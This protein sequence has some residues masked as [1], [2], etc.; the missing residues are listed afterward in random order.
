MTFQYVGPYVSLN[1]PREGWES[2]TTDI[3]GSIFDAD[4]DGTLE[5][6][7]GMRRDGGL[8][9]TQLDPSYGG[10]PGWFA[11]G[12]N[13]YTNH[14][15]SNY[16]YAG[17]DATLDTYGSALGDIL[18]DPNHDYSYGSASGNDSLFDLE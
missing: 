1:K 10:V 9:Y 3:E 8:S 17:L 2:L 11:S 5:M 16:D 6:V 12:G 13:A 7:D 15:Y 14:G 4:D 18:D